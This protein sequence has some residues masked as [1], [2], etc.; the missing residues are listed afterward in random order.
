VRLERQVSQPRRDSLHQIFTLSPIGE[1]ESEISPNHLKSHQF[2][3]II[4]QP[5]KS[6]KV[7]DDGL[8]FPF[9]LQRPEQNVRVAEAR[10][11]LQLAQCFN[12]AGNGLEQVLQL[13]LDAHHRRHLLVAHRRGFNVDQCR[14]ET[15][16]GCLHLFQACQFFLIEK[17]G[18][19]EPPVLRTKFHFHGLFDRQEVIVGPSC[20]CHQFAVI[21]GQIDMLVSTVKAREAHRTQWL[22][23]TVLTTPAFYQFNT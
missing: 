9:G 8:W 17:I 14:H 1:F 6:G 22:A 11:L 18:R 10:P 4:M 21:F 5:P 16:H 19:S 23:F 12:G 3:Q 13:A 2:K 15:L 7:H 20:L